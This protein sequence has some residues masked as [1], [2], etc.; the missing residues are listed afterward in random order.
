MATDKVKV[1]ITANVC[2]EEILT[3]EDGLRV[4]YKGYMLKAFIHVTGLLTFGVF[5]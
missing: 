5:D 4:A 3:R 1:S 2:T